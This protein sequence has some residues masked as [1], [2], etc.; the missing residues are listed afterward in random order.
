[1][2]FCSKRLPMR[3]I[4]SLLST[5]IDKSPSAVLLWMMIVVLNLLPCAEGKGEKMTRVK[6]WFNHGSISKVET[7]AER[8]GGVS[9]GQGALSCRAL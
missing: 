3:H 9:A 2:G 1:M 5:Y 6:E 4:A 8:M 7:A